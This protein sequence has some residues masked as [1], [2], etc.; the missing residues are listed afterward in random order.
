MAAQQVFHEWAEPTIFEL[1]S[2]PLVSQYGT[3]IWGGCCD[4]NTDS[5]DLVRKFGLGHRLDLTNQ[6]MRD[7]L[8]AVLNT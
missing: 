1:L 7:A 6:A 8:E 3:R 4:S 2:A 5:P